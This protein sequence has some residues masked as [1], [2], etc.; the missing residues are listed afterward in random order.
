MIES[1]AQSFKNL[2]DKMPMWMMCENMWL[3]NKNM[4]R[5]ARQFSNSNCLNGPNYWCASSN[6]AQECKVI[7][8]IICSTVFSC[9]HILHISVYLHHCGARRRIVFNIILIFVNV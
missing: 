2:S 1:Y 7:I 3:C 9:S 4:S 5:A 6:N 8:K